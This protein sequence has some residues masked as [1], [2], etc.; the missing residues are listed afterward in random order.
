MTFGPRD[1]CTLPVRPALLSLRRLEAKETEGLLDEVRDEQGGIVQLTLILRPL[2][3]LLLAKSAWA[4]SS[5][6]MTIEQKARPL[7]LVRLAQLAAERGY[8]RPAVDM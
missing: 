8:E 3:V 1:S 6:R 5:Q 4:R 7:R 2:E